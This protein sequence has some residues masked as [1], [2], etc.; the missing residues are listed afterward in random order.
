[1]YEDF[2]GQN[3]EE[4]LNVCTLELKRVFADLDERMND[5]SFMLPGGYKEYC[6]ELQRLANEYRARTHKQSMV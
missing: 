2:C 3:N 5:G 1:M 6:S 4:C